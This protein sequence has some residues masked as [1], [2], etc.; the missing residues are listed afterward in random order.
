MTL[1]LLVDFFSHKDVCLLSAII[2]IQCFLKLIL[3]PKVS[4]MVRS[5]RPPVR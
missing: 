3:D 4:R 1:T 2:V 5:R